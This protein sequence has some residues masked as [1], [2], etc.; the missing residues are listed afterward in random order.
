MQTDKVHCRII[1][2]RQ[3]FVLDF[4]LCLKNHME[5]HLGSFWMLFFFQSFVQATKALGLNT[6]AALN[7]A[8][9]D[10]AQA[11]CFSLLSFCVDGLMQD[12]IISI[13]LEMGI[14]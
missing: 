11:P 14:L 2:F 3:P 7:E 5:P 8:F 12:C 10:L 9:R 6:T 4:K 13:A 1:L